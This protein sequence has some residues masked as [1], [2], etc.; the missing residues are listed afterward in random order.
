M[1]KSD[2]IEVYPFE[3]PEP[4]RRPPRSS[5]Y[6]LVPMGLKTAF[7]E[8]L[9]SYIL[10]L[11]QAHTLPP[12][13]LLREIIAP[14]MA[15]GRFTSSARQSDLFR[16]TGNSFNGMGIASQRCVEALI[17]LTHQP[18][19]K[20]LNLQFLEGYVWGVGLLKARQS[21]CP[22]CL[23]QQRQAG[24][25]VHLP[26]AWNISTSSVCSIHGDYLIDRC[27]NCSHQHYALNRTQ[28]PGICPKCREFLGT[29]GNDE[30]HTQTQIDPKDSIISRMTL[31]LI[32]NGREL[33]RRQP[34]NRFA[35]NARAIREQCFSGNSSRMAALLKADRFSVDKW[36]AGEQLPKLRSLLWFA[37]RFGQQP[38]D[39]LTTD[40]ARLDRFCVQSLGESPDRA[41][42]QFQC[43]PN[44]K[45]R[46]G[47]TLNKLLAHPELPPPSLAKIAKRLDVDLTS[48]TRHFPEQA[49]IIKERHR[50]YRAQRSSNREQAELNAIT[51][52]VMRIH[53]SGD[54]PSL[55]QVRQQVTG[56]R[57][58][59]NPKL[60]DHW[61]QLVQ[62]L[63]Y[64]NP[65]ETVI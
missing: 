20:N 31:E 34:F 50:V 41:F 65:S 48:I 14:L 42:I 27:P 49:A 1:T 58:L 60:A 24:E 2:A 19:V 13:A 46:I 29:C 43:R 51:D 11:A 62:S 6:T 21:W 28:P 45:A 54:Y 4:Y 47:G 25:V 10:R 35:R 30:G 32:A 3:P 52:A 40:T 5:L 9:T 8:S 22:K 7:G 53:A 59:Q 33:L 64:P 16:A 56:S 63:G 23:R 39:L 37:W 44:S 38:L 17:I 18:L 36:C 12:S 26:L 15:K 57:M 61:R 55:H